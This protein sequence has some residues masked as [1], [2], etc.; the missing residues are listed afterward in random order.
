MLGKI[1][2]NLVRTAGKERR[3]ELCKEAV[4]KFPATG[5]GAGGCFW[6]KVPARAHI[7]PGPLSPAV[8]PAASGHPGSSETSDRAAS[9]CC[10]EREHRWP[11]WEGERVLGE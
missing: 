10:G 11:R 4:Q 3:S 7:S 9:L 8:L 6:G 5:R 2:A 1:K